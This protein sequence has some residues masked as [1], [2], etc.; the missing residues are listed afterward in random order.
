[1]EASDVKILENPKR[2]RQIR[3]QMVVRDV[4]IDSDDTVYPALT[5][6]IARTLE[7]TGLVEDMSQ[8]L[9]YNPA[10]TLH[11][12]NAAVGS[13]A[14]FLLTESF[15]RN[16]LSD[17]SD[18]AV[19]SRPSKLFGSGALSEMEMNDLFCEISRMPN[20]LPRFNVARIRR[21]GAK[22]LAVS[23]GMEPIVRCSPSFAKSSISILDFTEPYDPRILGGFPSKAA[24]PECAKAAFEAA[25]SLLE[26]TG[27][28][29]EGYD[30]TVVDWITSPADF[31]SLAKLEKKGFKFLVQSCMGLEPAEGIA[32]K[33]AKK[34]ASDNPEWVKTGYSS[35][36]I[37]GLE[38][39]RAEK[40]VSA[41]FLHE[42]TYEDATTEGLSW[43]LNAGHITQE[44]FNE[45][46]ETCG[47]RAFFTSNAELDLTNIEEIWYQNFDAIPQN[48][49]TYADCA[50]A[51]NGTGG[52]GAALQGR[53]FM[54]Y[55]VIAVIDALYEK[56]L[57]NAGNAND[58]GQ[59]LDHL[60]DDFVATLLRLQTLGVV[61]DEGTAE[62]RFAAPD[63]ELQACRDAAR[64]YDA[65]DLL[66]SAQKAW[67]GTSVNPVL[68]RIRAASKS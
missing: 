43:E 18:K 21:S 5:A 4:T 64:I 34:D 47:F 1:M 30:V 26:R 2:L 46:K 12:L 50:D 68:A 29:K 59:W 25:Q 60:P 62:M 51:Y 54:T 36:T 20:L 37:S 56:Y 44:E 32:R 58:D 55:V 41:V 35:E 9:G 14:S 49:K 40:P 52:D 24:Y 63:H 3:D 48:A 10:L 33:L 22:R 28:L 8:A 17:L 61:R 23:I 13:T 65:E 31:R 7:Q 15:R 16:E 53:F 6:L 45:R 19:V 42:K 57:K 66:E 11:L 27:A 67:D 38:I 39:P